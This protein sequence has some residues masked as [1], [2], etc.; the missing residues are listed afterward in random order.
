[1]SDEKQNP[2]EK[3]EDQ[4]ADRGFRAPVEVVASVMRVAFE[5]FHAV[6]SENNLTDHEIL[7]SWIEGVGHAMRTMM[8]EGGVRLCSPDLARRL[9]LPEGASAEEITR[10]FRRQKAQQQGVPAS[11]PPIQLN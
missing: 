1:M 2:I 9:G 3:L 4:T 11:V 5:E 10:E 6:C 8:A 7:H